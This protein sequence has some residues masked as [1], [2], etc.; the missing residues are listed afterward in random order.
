LH[1]SIIEGLKLFVVSDYTSASPTN[2]THTGNRYQDVRLGD[3]LTKGFR[4]SRDSLF[5]KIRLSGKTVLDI[6]SNLGETSRKMSMLGADKVF[7]LEFD[8][9]FHMIATALASE[10][11]LQNVFHL[12]GDSLTFDYGSLNFSTVALFSVWPFS[13]P[14]L[15]ELHSSGARNVILETH[16]VNTV[17][18]LEAYLKRILPL[19]P[20][21]S[22]LGSTDHGYEGKGKRF[23]ILFSTSLEELESMIAEEISPEVIPPL[24]AFGGNQGFRNENYWFAFEQAFERV[25][26]GASISEQATFLADQTATAIQG[27]MD[28]PGLQHLDYSRVAQL[29]EARLKD[30][31]YLS[32]HELYEV[33]PITEIISADRLESEGVASLG[34]TPLL[35][36][37][38]DGWHRLYS[39][40]RLRS[41]VR[42]RRVISSFQRLR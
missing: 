22:I 38:L 39:A 15:E 1:S 35:D 42:I 24:A 3:G 11:K 5:S 19:W 31:L 33:P 10:A 6:G 32:S 8:I 12:T 28:D 7:G 34:D 18:E 13:E 26:Q 30:F 21:Y 4:S 23:W 9:N 37:N 36:L 2:G 41:P 27:A 29:W 25:R 20:F 16:E 40:K 14:R 17:S